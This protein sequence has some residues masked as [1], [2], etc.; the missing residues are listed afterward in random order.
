MLA[1]TLLEA[2]ADPGKHTVIECLIKEQESTP[3]PA[4]ENDGEQS[5]GVIRA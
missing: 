2:E 5:E 1:L 4:A 3:V